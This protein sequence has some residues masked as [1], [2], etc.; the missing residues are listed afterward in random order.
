MAFDDR[1]AASW[2]SSST[3]SSLAP[4]LTRAFVCGITLNQ[5]RSVAEQFNQNWDLLVDD[6]SYEGSLNVID[7][8][9]VIEM[10]DAA[11][12][13]A[14][15]HCGVADDKLAM[16]ID[17]LAQFRQALGSASSELETLQ[18]LVNSAPLTSAAA[19]VATGR[20][21]STRSATCCSRP[22]RLG[23]RVIDGQRL[24]RLCPISY[25][26]FVPSPSAVPASAE[27]EDALSSTTCWS[28]P[29]SWCRTDVGVRVA[30]HDEFQRLLIDEFQDTDPIQPEL[31][32]RIANGSPDPA[33]GTLPG[34]NWKSKRAGCS[35]SAI[36]S[37]PSTDSGV[38]T[39]R[40]SSRLPISTAMTG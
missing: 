21:P 27:A 13:R 2:T 38:P 4:A 8:S 29:A 24:R 1:W 23:W 7:A 26:S 10:L 28:R 34:A 25:R 39:L 5:L 3:M 12:H 31:A 36:P 6:D 40:C 16:H 37:S 20:V 30:L 35:S 33:A 22:R 14:S 11:Q 9:P 18:L 19:N 15:E 17:G 32:V